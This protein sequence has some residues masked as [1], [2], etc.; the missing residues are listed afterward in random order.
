LVTGDS[1]INNKNINKFIIRKDALGVDMESCAIAQICYKV[2]TKFC[3]IKLISDYV[4]DVKPSSN[5]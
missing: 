2:N 5:Q 1:F 3:F 4:I